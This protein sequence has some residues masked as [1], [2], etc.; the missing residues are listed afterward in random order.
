MRHPWA[1][2]A[3]LRLLGRPCVEIEIARAILRPGDT[4]L[5]VGANAGQF[6]FVFST[7]VGKSGSVHAFEPVGETFA[8]LE[9]ARRT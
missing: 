7:L 6:T 4:V 8:R 3:S 1:Y 9:A 2:E 5:D